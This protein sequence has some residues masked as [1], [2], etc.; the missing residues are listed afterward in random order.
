M[1]LLLCVC[2]LEDDQCKANV[3]IFHI[4]QQMAGRAPVSVMVM[5]MGSGWTFTT[6][7]MKTRQ[8]W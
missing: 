2:V 5:T 4:V 1:V 6:R 7:V 3:P 8:K